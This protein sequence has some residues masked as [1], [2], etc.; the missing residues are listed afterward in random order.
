MLTTD[1]DYSKVLSTL[2]EWCY[3]NAY[4]VDDQGMALQT[5]RTG[6]WKKLQGIVGKDA[7]LDASWNETGS[8]SD[9]I[10]VTLRHVNQYENFDPQMLAAKSSDG[11]SCRESLSQLSHHDGEEGACELLGGKYVAQEAMLGNQHCLLK[12]LELAGDLTDFVGNLWIKEVNVSSLAGLENLRNIT[13]DFK[14]SSNA[15]L[16]SL[17]GLDSLISV[18]GRFEIS[19]NDV[20]TSLEGLENISRVEGD[21]AILNNMVLR[22]LDG[23]GGL[24][25]AGKD[26][27]ILNNTKVTSLAGLG[28]LSELKGDLHIGNALPSVEGLDALTQVRDLKIIA[29]SNSSDCTGLEGI[30]EL[31]KAVDGFVDSPWDLPLWRQDDISFV[32]SGV[33]L[34]YNDLLTGRKMGREEACQ[35]LQLEKLLRPASNES[36]VI[37]SDLTD[38]IYKE[39]DSR[40]RDCET[41]QGTYESSRHRPDSDDE[42]IQYHFCTLDGSGNRLTSS[43]FN[44]TLRVVDVTSLDILKGLTQVEG[45]LEIGTL[46][47]MRTRELTS[48]GGLESLRHVKKHMFIDHNPSLQNLKGLENLTEVGGRL[49]V[50]A[51]EGLRNLSGLESLTVVGGDLEIDVNNALVSLSGLESLTEVK[52]SLRIW[53]NDVLT[54]LSGL[55]NLI[56]VEGD[57]I[58]WNN[59]NLT[60]LD[61]LE[62]LKFIGGNL[63]INA[64]TFYGRCLSIGNP[65]LVVE[66]DISVINNVGLSMLNLAAQSVSGKVIV[67]D[68]NPLPDNSM[69]KEDEKDSQWEDLDLMNTAG[70]EMKSLSY[71]AGEIMIQG[72]P[73]LKALIVRGIEVVG[74]GLTVSSNSDLQHLGFA[75]VQDICSNLEIA[76]NPSLNKL[77]GFNRLRAV[78]GEMRIEGNNKLEVVELPKLV[79]VGIY[80]IPRGM[81]SDYDVDRFFPEHESFEVCRC[82]VNEFEQMGGLSINNPELLNFTAPEM[83]FVSGSISYQELYS[84]K[85]Q[86]S[87]DDEELGQVAFLA[88]NECNGTYTSKIFNSLTGESEGTCTM[89]RKCQHFSSE[90]HL[91]FFTPELFRPMCNENAKMQCSKPMTQGHLAAIV[92]SSI[93]AVLMLLCSLTAFF[94][95]KHRG[96][97]AAY[98]RLRKPPNALKEETTFAMTDIQDSTKLWEQLPNDVMASCM[99]L[100]HSCLYDALKECHGYLSYTEGDA[101]FVAFHFAQDAVKWSLLVQQ[102]LLHLPWPR[103]LLDQP[104]GA[105]VVKGG[106]LLFRG[107][108]VRIG[109]HSG[110]AELS[111]G[112]KA[113]AKV[114]YSGKAPNLTRM[115]C[116]SGDGGAVIITGSSLTASDDNTLADASPFHCGIYNLLSKAKS[117]ESKSVDTIGHCEEQL[118]LL[119]PKGLEKRVDFF[120]LTLAKGQKLS[121]HCLEA[122]RGDVTLCFMYVPVA[123]SLFEWDKEIASETLEQVHSICRQALY[124]NG[125][126]EAECMPGFFYASF[127]DSRDAVKWAIDTQESLMDFDWPDALL[128]LSM[129]EEMQIMTVKDLEPVQETVTVY[130]GPRVKMGLYSGMSKGSIDPLTGRMQYLGKVAN[131]TARI[132]SAAAQ[133]QILASEEV[134]ASFHSIVEG[135]CIGLD[136]SSTIKVQGVHIMHAGKMQLKGVTEPLELYTV[137]SSLLLRRPLGKNSFKLS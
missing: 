116:D 14:I 35:S 66:G 97:L 3:G 72:N 2:F 37:L 79:F 80:A 127:L 94:I 63:V 34:D 119:L 29:D 122:P 118:V 30:K 129:C 57:V 86:I 95:W 84:G 15:A 47:E 42:F 23:L 53:D 17:D 136:R 59:D 13:G 22:S 69:L 24:T 81:A 65:S 98:R 108:R 101:F 12:D 43:T 121:A 133:G 96:D 50:D 45:G 120:P 125:G 109:I 60:S 100:H 106:Q 26:V 10:L 105:E 4:E 88:C 36:R 113:T 77:T 131:R 70:S 27:M 58:I 52:G 71:V 67:L 73:S 62:N 134:V 21:L 11:K 85:S 75:N 20:L 8:G 56:S 107:L 6:C 68:N 92:G 93:G 124:R 25:T 99:K 40:R 126:Y 110:V 64:N 49:T 38:S 16:A 78:N 54:S 82:F 33:K 48:L 5:K 114:T 61:G 74:G 1:S 104:A 137:G 130:K 89:T 18:G 55:K 51:N 39:S 41:L 90:E 76:D 7:S 19:E 112:N 115:V 46:K 103:E 44:G 102:R 135:K 87:Y 31:M 83:A 9:S 111:E 32:T 132:A 91:D 117:S 28:K 128:D 123:E